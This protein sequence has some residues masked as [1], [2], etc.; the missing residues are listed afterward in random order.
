MI[1]SKILR[2]Q[3][4]SLRNCRI[5]DFGAEKLSREIGTI[6]NQNTKLLSLNLSGNLITDNGAI[7]IARVLFFFNQI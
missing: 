2:I 4:L 7:E 3:H 6:R 1:Y 5:T